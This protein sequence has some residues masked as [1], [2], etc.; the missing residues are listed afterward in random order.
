MQLQQH[1]CKKQQPPPVFQM[2]NK[3]EKDEEK[4]QKRFDYGANACVNYRNL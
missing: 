4:Y 2:A 1:V 3:G